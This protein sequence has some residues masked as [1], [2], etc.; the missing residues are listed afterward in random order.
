MARSA[1]P[2]GGAKLIHVIALATVFPLAGCIAHAPGSGGQQQLQVT[3]TASVP[4]PADV[5]VSTPTTAS[6]I[7]FTAAVTGTSNQAVTWTLTPYTGSGCSGNSLGT[8]TSTGT[9]TALFTATQQIP[10]IPCQT[11]VTAISSENAAFSGQAL[12]QSHVFVTVSPATDML[13]QIANLQYTATVT[14]APTGQTGVSWSGSGGYGAFDP[15]NPGVFIAGQLGQGVTSETE[16][17]YAAST[18]DPSQTGTATATIVKNDQ[19][20]AVS[21]V[22]TVTPCPADSNG[23]LA[24]GTCYSMTVSCDQV[25]PMTAYL[26]VNTPASTPVGTVIFIVGSG[27]NGLYDS[28]WTYGYETVETV[29]KANF[30]TVQV[31]F[32]A[33]FVTTQP[34][35]WLQGPGGVRRLA[36]RYATLANWVYNNAST[37]NSNTAGQTPYCATGNS[38]GAGAVAYAAT[39]YNLAPILTMIEPTGGPPM[40]R[41][42]WG[43]VCTSQM[44]PMDQCS[45]SA[46]SSMC[47]STA[48]AQILD[49]A[50]YPQTAKCSGGLATNTNLFASDSILDQPNLT[51]PLPLPNTTV[52]IVLGGADS[53]SAVPQGETW[54]QNVTPVLPQTQNQCAPAPA[55]H[56]IPDDP[57]GAMQIAVGTTVN[58]NYEPGIIAAC[59]S[60]AK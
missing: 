40:T 13:A 48:D 26:K 32:G 1:R 36:C 52:S 44:G 33:P 29:S 53:T 37:I 60:P 50:Y 18:F 12:V 51:E 41:M 55:G 46:P 7:T 20:G 15:N 35:G 9:N 4:L 38:A 22:Q 58:G 23:G 34:N 47:Y 56:E 25:A 28:Y 43:C 8:I 21:N 16:N 39:E 45:G 14:G 49:A 6:T 30:N 57:T 19:L 42:D 2:S 17:I 11:V 10:A 24:N 31:S 59:V 5:P 54:F 3:V 27:G